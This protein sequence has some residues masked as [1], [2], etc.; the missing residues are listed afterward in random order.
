MTFPLE[1]ELPPNPPTGTGL[2]GEYVL[3]LLEHLGWV[4]HEQALALV[5]LGNKL[6]PWNYESLLMAVADTMNSMPIWDSCPK[7]RLMIANM[8]SELIAWHVNGHTEG[9]QEAATE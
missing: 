2:T 9:Q 6:I 7:C 3:A 4:S 8:K 5:A 1:P